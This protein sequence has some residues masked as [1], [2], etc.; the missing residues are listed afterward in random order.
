MRQALVSAALLLHLGAA[1]AAGDAGSGESIYQRCGACHSLEHDRAGPRH[2]GLFGRK[3]G[4]VKDFPYS[5]GMKRSGIVWS[6]ATLDR[7]L[8]NPGEV[9]PGTP[10]AAF[11][12]SDAQERADLVAW[13]ERASASPACR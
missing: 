1:A 12:V 2:C 7:F 11:G 6:Q 3:A 8:A 10:M 13:L 4:S 9:V 5:E